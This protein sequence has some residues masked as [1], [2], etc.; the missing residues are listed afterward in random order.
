VLS[1]QVEQDEY[2]SALKE[3]YAVKLDVSCEILVKTDVEGMI[4][5][6]K[7]IMLSFDEKGKPKFK[8]KGIALLPKRG[9]INQYNELLSKPFQAIFLSEQNKIRKYKLVSLDDKAEWITADIQFNKNTLLISEYTINT[10]K[11][12]A[13][14]VANSYE[15]N[16]YPS[17][18][19]VT[20][21]IKK[22]KLPLKFIGRNDASVSKEAKKKNVTGT[23]TLFYTYIK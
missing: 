10:K 21:N 16:I 22:F 19:V 9:I 5:P 18:S 8:G 17:K 13:F 12:G 14:L 15:D 11:H 7:T 6:D 3:R 20:F 4:V 23:I 1:A 2:I